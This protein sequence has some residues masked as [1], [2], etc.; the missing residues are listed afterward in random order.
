MPPCH[1]VCIK[2]IVL[3]SQKGGSGKATLSLNLAIAVSRAGRQVVVIDLDPQQSAAR[4]SRLRTADNPVIIGTHGPNL[5]ETLDRARTAG[6][7]LAVV[8]TALKSEATA[9]VAAKLADFNLIPCQ[10]SN[11]DLDAVAESVNI[12]ALA[13]KPAAIV[14]TLCRASSAPAD[15]AEDA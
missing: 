4:W 2:T 15:Q 10:P 5:A 7:D 11:L 12:V 13:K 1:I 3:L 6:A 8:D 9:L 14:L